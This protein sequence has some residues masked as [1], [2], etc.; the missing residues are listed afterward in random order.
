[1]ENALK[2]YSNIL[3]NMRNEYTKKELTVK[4]IRNDHPELN[5]MD[6]EEIEILINYANNNR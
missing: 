3:D 2:E 1:M 6:N 4:A 5:F